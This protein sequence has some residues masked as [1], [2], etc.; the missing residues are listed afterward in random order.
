MKK[1][2]ELDRE[3]Y[4][5]AINDILSK[6]SDLWILWQIYLSAFHMTG[7]GKAEIVK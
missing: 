5:K 3:E 7:E 4:I 6:T 2:Y 1:Y